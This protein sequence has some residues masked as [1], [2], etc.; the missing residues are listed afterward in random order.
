MTFELDL[1]QVLFAVGAIATI[2]VSVYAALVVSQ[3]DRMNN[4][5]RL[6]TLYLFYKAALCARGVPAE[7]Q[8]KMEEALGLFRPP[9]PSINAIRARMDKRLE[10]VNFAKPA[11]TSNDHPQPSP[12]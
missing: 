5:G 1:S 9:T 11:K 6:G 2:A 3:I 8:D 7:K 10:S 4:H 12:R